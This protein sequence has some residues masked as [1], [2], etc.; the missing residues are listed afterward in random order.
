MWVASPKKDHH[1]SHIS[2]TLLHIFGTCGNFVWVNQPRWKLTIQNTHPCIHAGIQ[3][4]ICFPSTTPQNEK[5]PL[6]LGHSKSIG[7]GGSLYLSQSEWKILEPKRVPT[8]GIQLLSVPMFSIGV[9]QIH[10][11]GNNTCLPL[12]G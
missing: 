7:L 2:T 12:L 10:I 5:F 3:K 11:F 8:S 9:L 6:R 4:Y 1:K